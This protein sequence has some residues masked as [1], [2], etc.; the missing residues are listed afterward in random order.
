[1]RLAV[2]SHATPVAEALIGKCIHLD[3]LTDGCLG[4][5]SRFEGPVEI[6]GGLTGAGTFTASSA[7][8]Q[9]SVQVKPQAAIIQ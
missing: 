1:M 3:A 9:A 4:H 8:P 5:S 6:G 2:S 7:D